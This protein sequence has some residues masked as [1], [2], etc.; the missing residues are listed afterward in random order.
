MPTRSNRQQATPSEPATG[1]AQPKATSAAARRTRDWTTTLVLICGGLGTALG[2]VGQLAVVA[3]A[4]GER[5]ATVLQRLAA[6]VYGAAMWAV[7]GAVIGL[8]SFR[9]LRHRTARAVSIS[10]ASA[11]I[12]L[13]ALL[14]VSGVVLRVLSGS[15]LTAGAVMFSLNSS[16]HFLHGAAGPYLAFVVAAVVVFSSAT[17]FVAKKIRAAASRPT[18]N[19]R[20][21][22][23]ALCLLIALVAVYG[24]RAKGRF[25]RGMFINSPLLALVSSLENS[26]DLSRLSSQ[27]SDMGPLAPPG[28][29]R[30]SEAAW[31]NAVAA[32]KGERPNVLLLM[33]ESLAPAHMSSNGYHRATTPELDRIAR[34]GMV[35]TR[36]WTTATHSNYAQMAVLSSLFPR[37]GSGLDQYTTLNYPRTL[38]H[39]ALHQRGYANAT[40]SSQD[41][42]WQ[43]MR[44]FQQTDTPQFYFHSSDY[45]GTHLDSGVEK[46]VPDDATTDE[47]IRWLNQQGEQPW[48]LYVNFQSTHFP[49]TIPAYAKQPYQPSEPTPSTFTYLR[50]PKS[51]RDIVINRYDNA[52]RY[53]D[54]QVGRL[55]RALESRG[56]LDD[57]LWIITSDHGEQFFD[58]EDLVTHGRTVYEVEARVP[59]VLHW[60]RRIDPSRYDQ[61]ASHLDILP[62]VFELLSLPPHPSWQGRSLVAPAT[63]P[64]ASERPPAIFI[65]I[66]G[67]RFADSIVCWPYKLIL[68]RSRD[69]Q[70]LFHLQRD[71]SETRNLISE[72]PR[73]ARALADTLHKQLLAQLDYHADGA[74]ERDERFQP[75]L[76]PCPHLTP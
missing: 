31:R 19:P 9:A 47:I 46:T 22:G 16:E 44:R 38:L 10:V 4:P 29:P 45:Q 52:L 11:V 5:D 62:T 72:H 37:R 57:T 30:S 25:I 75:R 8:I 64:D 33:L 17:L 40:I 68:E 76:R 58:K 60:P 61:P 1:T 15:Y 48:A 13:V 41:E 49:Y 18:P 2:T 51:E 27:P 3:L 24:Q 35:A 53:V 12:G 14:L 65:N 74:S 71:P 50:Y 42:N 59:I 55:R 20:T 66:Q 39:D 36:A 32:A 67:L 26:Y 23:A 56:E 73:I 6:V 34:D 43:G 70:M 54:E 69:R 7:L 21:V 63:T 28:P